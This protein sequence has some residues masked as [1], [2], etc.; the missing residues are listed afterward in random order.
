MALTVVV[1]PEDPTKIYVHATANDNPRDELEQLEQ[2]GLIKIQKV[3]TT[4]I[5]YPQHPFQY[6]TVYHY[7]VKLLKPHSLENLASFLA[8][9]L[10]TINPTL[11]SFITK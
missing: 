11:Y 2:L 9:L 1:S 5:E 4:K 8:K 10:R 3:S 6:Y 7:E